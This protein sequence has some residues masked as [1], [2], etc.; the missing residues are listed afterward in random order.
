M[1]Q[2]LILEDENLNLAICAAA[3]GLWRMVGVVKLFSLLHLSQSPSTP[4][5]VLFPTH[6]CSLLDPTDSPL[7]RLQPLYH[8]EPYLASDGSEALTTHI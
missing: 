5:R 7:F 4:H 2:P 8:S 1:P 3:N 6:H